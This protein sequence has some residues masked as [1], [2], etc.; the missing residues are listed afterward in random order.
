MTLKHSR[1]KMWLQGAQKEK[2]SS[3]SWTNE[4]TSALNSLP[5]AGE[6]GFAALSNTSVKFLV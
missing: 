2:K 3:T 6:Q 1:V 4:S 5:T